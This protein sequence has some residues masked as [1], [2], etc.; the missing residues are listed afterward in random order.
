M[1]F[2][3]GVIPIIMTTIFHG[4]IRSVTT[5]IKPRIKKH[6]S[7][8]QRS[9]SCIFR[10]EPSAS[11]IRDDVLEAISKSFYGLRSRRDGRTTGAS[12]L[13]DR[14][15][16][17]MTGQSFLTGRKINSWIKQRSYQGSCFANSI[18]RGIL[19]LSR[20]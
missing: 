20:L 6:P 19:P 8:I 11:R 12:F 18:F 7:L 13:I 9:P 10:R 16:R 17:A 2:V 1:P 14:L 15:Q 4:S 3:F 5:T